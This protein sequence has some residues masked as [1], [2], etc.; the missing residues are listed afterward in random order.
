MQSAQ[1]TE[2]LTRVVHAIPPDAVCDL[3]ASVEKELKLVSRSGKK[4]KRSKVS[5]DLRVW[6][7][8]ALDD[9]GWARRGVEWY[10][11]ERS[12]AEMSC[13]EVR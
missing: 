6:P 8:L 10:G 13:V 4:R 5:D 9:I 7:L 12:G 2:V 11:L 1:H 3:R